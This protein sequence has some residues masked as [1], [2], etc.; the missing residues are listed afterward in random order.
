VRGKVNHV[1]LEE[2]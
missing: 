1:A 2:T